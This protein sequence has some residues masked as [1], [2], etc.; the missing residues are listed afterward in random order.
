MMGMDP[1]LMQQAMNA[2]PGPQN[3]GSARRSMAAGR[4]SR[5]G[6]AAAAGATPW[7]LG[8]SQGATPWLPRANPEGIPCTTTECNKEDY[9]NKSCDKFNLFLLNPFI[10]LQ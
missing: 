4:D 7:L 6:W 9:T 2:G 1:A 5:C 3:H 8:A 10:V